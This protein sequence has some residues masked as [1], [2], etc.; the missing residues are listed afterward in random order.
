MAIF[1]PSGR[2]NPGLNKG[3]PARGVDPFVNA[4]KHLTAKGLPFT[5]IQPGPDANPGSCTEAL[6]CSDN[7]HYL[8]AFLKPLTSLF[9]PGC[10]RVA[11]NFLFY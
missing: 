6:K 1:N 11:L 4:Y 3:Y 10:I 8:E 5:V 7:A 9:P 2:V